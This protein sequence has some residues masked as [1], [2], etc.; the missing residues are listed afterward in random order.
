MF[1]RQT[2][3][4]I[5]PRCTI[6]GE[7]EKSTNSNSRPKYKLGKLEKSHSGGRTSAE[8]GMCP[9]VRLIRLGCRTERP[10]VPLE[11]TQKA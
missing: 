9:P 8:H 6:T 5:L 1:K 7:P 4:N 2:F 10:D 3:K 11:G